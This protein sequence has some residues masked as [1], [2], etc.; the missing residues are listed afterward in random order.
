MDFFTTLAAIF[1]YEIWA[2]SEETY[3][4]RINSLYILKFYKNLIFKKTKKRLISFIT[5]K[6]IL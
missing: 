3:I 5:K 6:I 4:K 1:A 2:D